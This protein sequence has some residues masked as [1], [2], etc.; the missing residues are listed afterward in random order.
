MKISRGLIATLIVLAVVI[1]DQVVKIYVKTHFYLGESYEVT[2]WFKI[3]FIENNGMAFGWELGSKLLL[4]LFRVVLTVLLIVYMWGLRHRT[5]IKTGYMVC[6]ALITA[7]AIGNILDCAFYGL[8]FNN[9]MPPEVAVMFPEG[10]GY[11]T[12]LHGRVVDML[13]FPLFSWYWPHWLPVVG[14]DRFEFFQPVF[15]IADAAISVGIIA[16][17]LFY[18]NSLMNSDK[19]ATENQD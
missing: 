14:G 16:L 1:I 8:I 11:G 10:G 18:R 19:K 7:G 4:T 3:H 5:D 6:L 15:N 12:F 17:L 9:P 13:Y 2:S